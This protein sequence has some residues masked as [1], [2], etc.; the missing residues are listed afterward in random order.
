M[1]KRFRSGIEECPEQFHHC[2]IVHVLVCV[3]FVIKN[4]SY[5]N[6]RMELNTQYKLLIRPFNSFNYLNSVSISNCCYNKPRCIYA[7]DSLVMP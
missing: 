1:V 2:Y 5:S 6:F 4:F 7:S 3:L